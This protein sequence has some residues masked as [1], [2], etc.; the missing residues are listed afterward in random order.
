MSSSK[1]RRFLTRGAAALTAPLLLPS[2]PAWTEQNSSADLSPE[3]QSANSQNPDPL[4]AL[5]KLT[6]LA[7]AA[8]APRY[9]VLHPNPPLITTGDNVDGDLSSDWRWDDPVRG[10]VFQYNAP[11]LVEGNELGARAA[12]L[13]GAPA[14]QSLRVTFWAD[15]VKL[16][17]MGA[18][19]FEPDD[20][21]MF[22][23]RFIV[24]GQYVSFV[25]TKP[26]ARGHNWIILDWQHAGGRAMRRVTLE[27]GANSRLVRLCVAPTES[28]KPVGGGLLKFVVM[29]DSYGDGHSAS[30]FSDVWPRLLGDRLG[31][32]AV[33]IRAIGGTGLIVGSPN[34]AIDRIDDITSAEADI[35]LWAIGSNDKTHSPELVRVAQKV[36]LQAVR[37]NRS[38]GRTPIFIF[39]NWTHSSGPDE[40]SFI[41]EAALF[42][43]ACDLNDPWIFLVPVC[44]LPGGP[45]IFGTGNQD[46]PSGRGNADIYIA[47]GGHPTTE[48][49]LYI[50]E[51]F[52]GQILQ[53]ISDIV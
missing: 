19:N 6:C 12:T 45:L 42:A 44:S 40:A 5:R 48:G 22:W 30:N 9:R 26:Y 43:G 31:A 53:S 2:Q 35:I 13:D 49:H 20:L 10:A 4:K 8:N 33:D 18:W 47:A 39:G 36:T 50:A 27:F 51:V 16:G 29:A 46:R 25:G 41:N 38:T 34:R 52:A 7:A 14:A 32:S 11:K 28:L 37:N 15:C 17:I 1:R 24:D 21:H 3:S 23:P